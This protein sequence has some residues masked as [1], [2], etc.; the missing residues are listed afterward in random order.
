MGYDMHLN[1]SVVSTLYDGNCNSH[2]PYMH[3]SRII[4][5]KWIT[6]KSSGSLVL[7]LLG[8]MKPI[9]II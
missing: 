4:S 1:Y 6:L 7:L 2:Y 9:S 8:L 5:M 3:V